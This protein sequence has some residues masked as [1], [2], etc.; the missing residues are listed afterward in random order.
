M[1]GG[2]SPPT[3]GNPKSASSLLRRRR[4]IPAHAGEP[5]VRTRRRVIPKVYPRPRGGTELGAA[6]DARPDGLSPPTRGNLWATLAAAAAARS[7]P[8]HAGEPRQGGFAFLGAEVYP[9]PR[10]GTFTP[11]RM[12]TGG[13]GLSPPTRGNRAVPG[14]EWTYTRSIPAH[15]GEPCTRCG[16]GV[17]KSV[18]PRPRG[19]T[20]PRNR[21]Q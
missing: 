4:S 13:G 16:A 8:A 1:F 12:K 9:R 6:G 17:K 10:G 5:R 11:K 15:A 19:G 20:R 7:I 18:Y 2:L 14:I 3:R 21:R